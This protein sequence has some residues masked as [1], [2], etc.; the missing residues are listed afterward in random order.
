MSSSASASASAPHL[1]DLVQDTK[2]DTSFEGHFTVHHYDDS[3]GEQDARPERRSEYWKRSGLL[4]CGGCGAVYLETLEKPVGCRGKPSCQMRAVKYVSPKSRASYP[5]ELE[6]IAKFSQRRSPADA[7]CRPQYSKYFVKMLGW[8]HQ[9]ENLCI[10]MEYFPLG[11]LQQYLKENGPM[12]DPDAQTVTSQILMGLNLMH[13]EKFAHRDIKPSNVLIKGHPPN[14]WWVKISDF[15]FSKRLSASMEELSGTVGTL[16]YIAPELLDA[17]KEGYLVRHQ[18]ADMWALG[19]TVS[20]M[21]TKASP[22]GSTAALFRYMA[23]PDAF[24]RKH[25]E[26]LSTLA[27][28]FIRSVMKPRPEER[29]SPSKALCHEWFGNNRIS[30][31]LRNPTS[32]ISPATARAKTP[33]SASSSAIPTMRLNQESIVGS[34]AVVDEEASA[35]FTSLSSSLSDSNTEPSAASTSFGSSHAESSSSTIKN[36]TPAPDKPWGATATSRPRTMVR[37]AKPPSGRSREKSA[38]PWR[39]PGAN[40]RMRASSTG[41]GDLKAARK[42]TQ[43]AAKGLATS[44]WARPER[45]PSRPRSTPAQPQEPTP[46]PPMYSSLAYPIAFIGKAPGK[47][48]VANGIAQHR[49]HCDEDMDIG[50]LEPF[51]GH[52]EFK[53][54]TSVQGFLTWSRLQQKVLPFM[55][56]RDRFSPLHMI[57]QS[58]PGTGKTMAAI[59][60]VISRIV[61][62]PPCPQVLF[63]VSTP[64]LATH[65][66]DTINNLWTKAPPRLEPGYP[67]IAGRAPFNLLI[68]DHIIVETSDIGVDSFSRLLDLNRIRILVI[69]EADT[70]LRHPATLQLKE[71]LPRTTQVLVLS[72]SYSGRLMQAAEYMAPQ[73]EKILPVHHHPVV[74]CIPQVYIDGRDM[75]EDWKLKLL[76]NLY[77]LMTIGS[78]AVFVETLEKAKKVERALVANGLKTAILDRDEK[79]HDTLKRFL[80]GRANCLISTIPIH[81]FQFPSLSMI[82]NYDIPMN[83]SSEENAH[84]YL[85]RV[86]ALRSLNRWYRLCVNFVHDQQS[87]DAMADIANYFDITIPRL[88][89]EDMGEAAE[90]VEALVKRP[91]TD[92]Q[93]VESSSASEG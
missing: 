41:P 74:R 4:G 16:G 19:V 40:T 85:R 39:S 90:Q 9:G 24:P 6:T 61:L 58:Q 10:A 12:T 5:P 59:L 42:T 82:V 37:D 14:A 67:R 93:V 11:D 68:G 53:R 81:G 75:S 83:G 69:D 20:V 92:Y 63:L 60:A 32:T 52:E 3:D 43:L 48:N 51:F 22:F 17:P 15:G 55:L 8:Y 76:F 54:A 89:H 45:T 29:L 71:R 86:G 18:A 91:R 23:T 30:K 78:S 36:Q 49:G 64:E 88:R 50:N 46:S 35:A 1:P 33:K 62:F 80:D 7:L 70:V 77:G 73:A 44:R 27:D 13:L 56:L 38:E 87:F 65:V 34:A 72:T 31:S 66:V 47:Y 2:L 79:R 84:L 28:L 25:K 21:L 26:D 57:I